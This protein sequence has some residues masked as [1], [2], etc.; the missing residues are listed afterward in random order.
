MSE[1]RKELVNRIIRLY[2]HENPITIQFAQM[3][4]EYDETRW[5]NAVLNL[6][7]ESHE[8]A[9]VCGVDE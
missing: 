7:V 6:L 5:N 2:G 8:F 4:E 1:E 3:C 9:A